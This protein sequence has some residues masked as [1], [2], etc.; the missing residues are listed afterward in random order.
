[1]LEELGFRVRTAS[2][3]EEAVQLFTREKDQIDCVILDLTMPR[4]DGIA[5][6]KELRRVQ[7]DVKI[8]LS[9][10]YNEQDVSGRM[11]DKIYAGFIQKPYK[12]Q[13]LQNELERVLA[14]PV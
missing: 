12:L 13:G 3:G 9:S 14:K 5:T 2:H 8:I 6:L 11:E 7:P 1:M 10:G 4:M